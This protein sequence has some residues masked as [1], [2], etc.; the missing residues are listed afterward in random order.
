[1]SG[2]VLWIVV[3][4]VLAALVAGG[5][6]LFKA[7]ASGAS[8]RDVFFKPRIEPR[9]GVVEHASVDGK[10]RLIL[11]RRDD[12][13]HLIMTGGPVDVVIET[14]IGEPPKRAVE[15]AH[16]AASTTVFTRA[17]RGFGQAARPET[18]EDEADIAFK[19]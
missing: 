13:E 2:I 19:R 12:V 14:G 6:V 1:M 3:L 7:Y 11:I 9:I 15:A 10:R 4:A 18:A 17:P 5:A 8:P 16:P